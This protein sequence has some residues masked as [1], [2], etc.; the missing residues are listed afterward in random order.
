MSVKFYDISYIFLLRL[1][2]LFAV[3]PK[4]YTLDTE[5]IIIV[6]FLVANI[7]F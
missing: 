4:Y 6:I 5:K 1:I 2:K 3:L 7:L